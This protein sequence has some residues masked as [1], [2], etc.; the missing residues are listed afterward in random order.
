MTNPTEPTDE[1]PARKVS[2]RI[3]GLA[4]L[5]AVGQKVFTRLGEA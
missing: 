2:P 3:E 5:D 1:P 4:G